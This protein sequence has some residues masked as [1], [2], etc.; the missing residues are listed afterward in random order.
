M[1]CA[2]D[3]RQNKKALRT[4]NAQQN[5]IITLYRTSNRKCCIAFRLRI[6]K[7]K[8]K[9]QRMLKLQGKITVKRR[10]AYKYY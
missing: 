4:V 6:Y 3:I 8:L 5:N 10:N 7:L 1:I 2:Y 9:Q